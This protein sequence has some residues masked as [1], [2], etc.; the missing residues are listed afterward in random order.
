MHDSKL[1]R[2]E[3]QPT[4]DMLDAVKC[5]LCRAPLVARMGHHGP[6][7]HCQCT[8]RAKPARHHSARQTA[9]LTAKTGH[10]AAELMRAIG[11]RRPVC[12]LQSQM[13]NGIH[14]STRI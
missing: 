10:S 6:Y 11:Q 14:T 9:T 13:P 12:T 2:R 3:R 4:P 5:P 1:L 8:P 7:F